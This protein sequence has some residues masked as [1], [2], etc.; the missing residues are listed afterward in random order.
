M[1]TPQDSFTTPIDWEKHFAEEQSYGN[2]IPSKSF[3]THSPSHSILSTL[4]EKAAV[5]VIGLFTLGVGIL[6]GIGL[7]YRMEEEELDAE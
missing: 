4:K 6:A 5:L 7:A 3:V 2:P 1:S